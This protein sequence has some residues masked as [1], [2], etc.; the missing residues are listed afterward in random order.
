MRPMP[1]GSPIFAKS[2]G[3]HTPGA[4]A[5]PRGMGK[6]ARAVWKR[7]TAE[8]EKAGTLTHADQDILA[9]YCVAVADLDK[10][11]AEIERDGIM[12]DAPTFDRNGKPT[13]STSR[14]PHPALKWR[15]D[16][17]NKVKQLAGEMGLTP[18]ARSR[19]TAAASTGEKPVN[20]VAA[21]RDRIAAAR[22]AHAAGGAG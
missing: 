17:L 20:K 4:P 15:S 22:A 10:L 3:G 11:N 5:V 1:A 18:A 2:S 16:L 13:G 6:A 19:V 9:A 21:L 14:R 8:M 7:V 12:I